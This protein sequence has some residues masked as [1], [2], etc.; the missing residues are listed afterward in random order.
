MK[1]FQRKFPDLEA[2]ILSPQASALALTG[3]TF[4]ASEGFVTADWSKPADVRFDL[5]PKKSR[6]RVFGFRLYLARKCVNPSAR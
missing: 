2:V 5:R 3:S 1:D 6:K 4:D